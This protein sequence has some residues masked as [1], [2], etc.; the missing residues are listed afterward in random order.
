MCISLD[1][2]AFPTHSQA[3]F[4]SWNFENHTKIK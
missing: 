1:D 2:F 4:R 3:V